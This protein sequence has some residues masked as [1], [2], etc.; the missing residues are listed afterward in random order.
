MKNYERKAINHA[1]R[2]TAYF[3]NEDA[4]IASYALVMVLCSILTDA[5]IPLNATIHEM[6]DI[7]R[8]MRKAKPKRHRKGK[9]GRIPIAV[10]QVSHYTDSNDD[11]VPSD[12]IPLFRKGNN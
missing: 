3:M 9:R 12:V 6:R 11:P 2:I 10:E 4:R 7:A 5:G 8:E 1:L